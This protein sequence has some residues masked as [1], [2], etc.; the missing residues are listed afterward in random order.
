V[1]KQ[2]QRIAE[3]RAMAPEELEAHMRQQRRRLFEV[4]FQQATGQVEDHQQIRTLRREIAQAMTVQIETRRA[5]D[6]GDDEGEED[7]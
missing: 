3:L 2:A 1:T 6:R 7:A 4:R 5:A